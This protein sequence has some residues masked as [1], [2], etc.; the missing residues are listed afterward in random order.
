MKK[1]KT[2]RQSYCPLE[3]VNPTSLL[4]RWIQTYYKSDRHQNG[5]WPSF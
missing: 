2:Y 5:T 4:G 1:Y 3:K